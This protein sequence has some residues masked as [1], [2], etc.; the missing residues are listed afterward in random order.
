[1]SDNEIDEMIDEIKATAEAEDRQYQIDYNR[2]SQM[3]PIAVGTKIHYHSLPPIDFRTEA[4]GPSL[5]YGGRP[6]ERYEIRLFED[7]DRWGDTR[8]ET[9]IFANR[10]NLEEVL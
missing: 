6:A 3:P 2:R 4:P 7:V 5:K 10:A 8:P 9:T 1:M